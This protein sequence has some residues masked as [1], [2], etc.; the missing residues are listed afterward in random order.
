MTKLTSNE[1]LVALEVEVKHLIEKQDRMASQVDQ[2]HTLL[3]QAKGVRWVIVGGAAVAGFI[4]SFATNLA[5]WLGVG[6]R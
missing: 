3:L 6:P 2:M 5:P 1:R 4:A